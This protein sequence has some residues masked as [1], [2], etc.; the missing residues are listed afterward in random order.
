MQVLVRSR[1]L[2]MLQGLSMRLEAHHIHLKGR[3]NLGIQITTEPP[4]IKGVYY[5][6]GLVA[7]A[8]AKG[9]PSGPEPLPRGNLCCPIAWS[10][11][12]VQCRVQ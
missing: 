8:G 4:G 5:V 2:G 7:G 10:T 11:H 12:I 1:S 6:R 9:M 3:M